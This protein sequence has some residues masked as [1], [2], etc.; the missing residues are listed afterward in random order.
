L[1]P[2]LDHYQTQLG[3]DA[4]DPSGTTGDWHAA[5]GNSAGWQQWSV[6]L[7]AWAGGTVEVSIAYAS[8]WATQN[9]GAFVDDV[10]LPDGTTT[11]FEGDMGGW[12]PG[13]PPAGSGPNA[14]NWVRTTAAGFP[15]GASI[16]TPH[17][18]LMGFGFEGI[19]TAEARAVVM[20][21]VMDHL[22]P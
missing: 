12:T 19:E 10:T 3:E 13:G 21:R 6:D 20:G 11:S 16:T 14:N 1:H 8:D 2:F 5:S 9:L 18:I 15:V 22:L 7:S 4:C 17:S